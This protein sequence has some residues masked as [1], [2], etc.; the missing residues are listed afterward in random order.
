MVDFARS[1]CL[2]S[3]FDFDFISWVRSSVIITLIF[4]VTCRYVILSMKNIKN[5]ICAN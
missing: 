5:L 3:N 1:N 2:E 4:V